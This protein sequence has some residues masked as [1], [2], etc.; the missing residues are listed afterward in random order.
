MGE[1]VP[2]HSIAGIE[3]YN[4]EGQSGSGEEKAVKAE[5]KGE[6]DV[7]SSGVDF[8]TLGS[9]PTSTSQ[10]LHFLVPTNNPNPTGTARPRDMVYWAFLKS[11][12]H[13]DTANTDTKPAMM[14]AKAV[15]VPMAPSVGEK[16][17]CPR[18]S[19]KGALRGHDDPWT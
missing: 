15:S 8:G 16:P 14:L 17:L 1:K 11:I 5:I 13:L 3:H 18:S 9:C 19:E 4:K 2:Y 6:A 10:Y 7:W 12:N